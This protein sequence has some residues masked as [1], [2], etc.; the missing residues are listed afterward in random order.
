MHQVAGQARARSM[1]GGRVYIQVYIWAG[2]L[3]GVLALVAA[4]SQGSDACT[5]A[6]ARRVYS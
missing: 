5:K 2:M 4:G 1:R 6:P 3:G